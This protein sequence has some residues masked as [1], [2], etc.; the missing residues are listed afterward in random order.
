M[1]LTFTNTPTYFQPVLSDGIFFTLS[2]DTANT[3]KFRY[4]YELYVNG[5]NVFEGKCTPNPYGL[6]IVDLQQV[7]ET[8]CNNNPISLWNNTYIY[9]HTTFPFS[10]PYLDE[11]ISYYIKAGYEYA[12]TPL[13]AITGFTGVGDAVGDP[14]YTSS[15]YKT[16]RSTMGVNGRATQQ[17]FDIDP[18]ILSGTPTTQNPTQSGLFLTNSPRYRDIAETEYYTLAF[19]NYY[20]EGVTANTLSE[21]YYVQFTFYD[22]QGNV[23]QQTQY[24]NITT[25]GGGPRQYCSQVYPALQLINTP[26]GSTSYNTLYVGAGPMNNGD[27]PPDTAQYTIQLFGKFTGSTSPIQPT[28]TPTPTGR[29]CNCTTY[30]LEAITGNV[31]LSYFNCDETQ[32]N[33]LEI[34]AGENQY[35]CA[36]IN[37]VQIITGREYNLQQYGSCAS[38][39]PTPTP[40]NICSGCTSYSLEY[41]GDSE[42][43]LITITN[44][45]TQSSDSFYI[46]G[47]VEYE[48]CSCTTPMYVADVVVTNLGS[49]NPLP[50]ATPTKTPT[51]TP[52]KTPTNTPSVVVYNYLGKTNPDQ[53]SGPL[54]CSN[55]T[56]TR[57]Y[58]GLK[59]LSSLTVGDYLYDTYPSTPTNGG[60]LWIALKVGGVGQ[61]YSF[62]VQS[63]GEITDTYT[64]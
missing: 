30:N 61:A 60:G 45:I 38:P 12:S 41:T 7:L 40:V 21:P 42:N 43:A 6:G 44:C 62:E 35:F 32:Y 53:S 50:S 59:P 49:C 10:R 46:A 57:G 18:Y 36:C 24:D 55:Y 3:Y 39:T 52:T 1:S 25:N 9:T 8:Y 13:G 2:A 34:A 28:P 37:T 23:I 51:P 5:Q 17:D 33:I 29:P 19:T 47:G 26:S 56:T 31:V 22:I 58:S 27:F 15:V 64:C 4:V 48:V 63:D 14:A 11:T 54:A 20:L 16:F